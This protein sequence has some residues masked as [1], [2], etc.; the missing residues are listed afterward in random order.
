M[1]SLISSVGNDE[2]QNVEEQVEIADLVGLFVRHR[3]TGVE[4]QALV[5]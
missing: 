5:N 1:A 3:K 4:P 2:Y